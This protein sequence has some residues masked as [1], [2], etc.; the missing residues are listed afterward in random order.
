MCTRWLWGGLWFGVVCTAPGDPVEIGSVAD[1]PSHWRRL[2]AVDNGTEVGVRRVGFRFGTDQEL[3]AMHL[4]ESEIGSERDPAETPQPLELYMALARSL[5]RQFGDNTWLAE[6]KESTPAGCAAC[7]SNS[8]GDPRVMESYV[9]VRRPWRRQRI[10]WRLLRAVVDEARAEGRSSL[11]WS[12]D[13]SVPA[14]VAFSR[15]VGGRTARVNWTSELRFENVDWE[16]VRTW[17]EGGL[18]RARGYTLEFWDGPFP[19]DLAEDAVTIHHIVQTAPRDDLEIGDVVLTAEH[20]AELDRHLVEAGRERWTVFVRDPDGASVGGTEVTF[21]RWAPTVAHQQN[22]AI[23]PSHR[24]L[25]LAKWAK[26]LML[27]RIRDQRPG[28]DRVRTANAFSNEPM[29]AINDALGFTVVQVRTEWQ[30]DITWMRS[31][32]P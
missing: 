30:G 32:M 2:S 17:M 9:Y 8:A 21:E 20:V 22:T 25:G 11:V 14:G 28:V 26:A 13:G 19:A 7:W 6:T 23:D 15:R 29:L 4:V 31:L 1:V 5:P 18:G 24:G 12:T 16:M 3:Q 10:G 27:F